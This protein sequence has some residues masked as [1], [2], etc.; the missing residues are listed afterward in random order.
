LHLDTLHKGDHVIVDGRIVSS[1]YENENS[2]SK[3]AKAAKVSV[4]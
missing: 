3:K 2:K 4:F 1:K